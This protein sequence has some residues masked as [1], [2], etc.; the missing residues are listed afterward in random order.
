MKS[1]NLGDLFDEVYIFEKKL[2]IEIEID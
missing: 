2:I 1:K